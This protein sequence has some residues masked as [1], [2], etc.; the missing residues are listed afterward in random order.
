MKTHR[1]LAA[2]LVASFVAATA[3]AG[4][5]TGTWKWSVTTPNGDLETTLRLTLKDGQIAGTYSNA[6]GD[7]SISNASFKDNAIAFDVQ[8]EFD[9]NRFVLKYQG[10]LDGDAIKGTIELP[11]M[12]GGEPRKLDWNARR[13]GEAPPAPAR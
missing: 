13:A 4:D 7:A 8:R 2:A 9:G 6:F 12:D 1:L 5:P 11:G 3:Y 10:K